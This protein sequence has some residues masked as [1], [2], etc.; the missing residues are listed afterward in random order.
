[1]AS[2]SPSRQLSVTDCPRCRC[3]CVGP[4]ILPCGHVLCRPCLRQLLEQQGPDPTCSSC[5]HS[6][7]RGQG[8]TISEQLDQFCK[9][10]VL[11]EIVADHIF[12]RSDTSCQTCCKPA[13]TNVCQDCG[14]FYCIHCSENHRTEH[15]ADC[16]TVVDPRQV[17][18][19][20]SSTTSRPPGHED[21]SQTST[22][23]LEFQRQEVKLLEEKHSNHSRVESDLDELIAKLQ[24]GRDRVRDQK[25][26]LHMYTTRMPTTINTTS[27]RER[28]R[29]VR[30][31]MNLLTREVLQDLRRETDRLVALWMEPVEVQ[32]WKSDDDHGAT[33]GVKG[34][35]ECVMVTPKSTTINWG[36]GSVCVEQ[37][38]D[39]VIHR[40]VKDVAIAKINWSE[41]LARVQRQLEAEKVKGQQLHADMVGGQQQLAAEK[42]KGQQ[43]LEAEKRRA[44]AELAAL[45]HTHQKEKT[46]ERERV[47]RFYTGIQ[48]KK[49]SLLK[50]V[51]GRI[52]EKDV[53]SKLVQQLCE[54][55]DVRLLAID[56]GLRFL[57]DV[58]VEEW[59]GVKEL[60]EKLQKMLEDALLP[61]QEKEEVTWTEV[62]SY[63]TQTGDAD[64]PKEAD[65]SGNEHQQTVTEGTTGS[66]KNTMLHKQQ[67][68][69]VTSREVTSCSTDAGGGEVRLG[70]PLP[71]HLTTGPQTPK[72]AD[73]SGNEHQQT[74]TEGTTGSS[75]NTMLHKQQGK[76][77]TSR[78]VT[79]CSTNAGGGEVR[80][81]QPLPTHLT[82]GPQTPKEA[83]ASG[84]EHQ[85]TVTEGTTGSAKNTMLHKQQGKEVTSREVTSCSTDAGGGEV[86]L[87]QPLPTHLTTGPQTPKEADA[88]GNEHQQTVTEGTTG[89]AKNTM[90]HKQQGKEV[91]SREVTSCST[92]AGGGEV[93][94]GQPLPTHL[95]TGPQTPKEADASGNEHQQTV[96]EGTTGSAKNTMLHKQQGKEVTSR[97]VTSCSTDAGGGEV[98]LGQPLPTH[99]TTGPQ[100]PKEADASG[101][102]HQ[103]TVTEG[104]TGSAKNTMLHKQQGKEVTSREV[105]SCSTDAG[106]GEVRLGQP[107]PT[108]LTTGPQTQKETYA[109]GNTS[110][111]I[112]T[113]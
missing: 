38:S 77:V 37:I 97:E 6:I 50:H 53:L 113:A 95:T 72:E 62:T 103:Q 58:P 14:T 27:M 104:T 40:T 63:S 30:E 15:A 92:D 94:L 21:V 60:Q 74:V 84:N 82:T 1:M 91:T 47:K 110:Q 100:T 8:Q 89:S 106:G 9:D 18:I 26:L 22:S 64:T 28:L 25:H 12:K 55:F 4:T 51:M 112:V 11:Q 2:A 99:L 83:D 107:L 88:S 80:L 34:T 45:Y 105:T 48:Q 86:R 70:Q 33:S 39:D 49:T 65:A 69:E 19:S 78:E 90:L 68:K 71:T 13:W 85:Q 79:S 109:T 35:T 59:K 87:G 31:D 10:L 61:K 46:R 76:E 93:R 44:E 7:P 23:L 101:N 102:E 36:L 43:Q 56:S 29:R 17:L 5:G 57:M 67:G 73:A 66:A 42:V 52:E 96:T 108:H 32:V 111:Q 54:E 98:R 41:N 3:L 20:A 81:G 75:K 16:H 24:N